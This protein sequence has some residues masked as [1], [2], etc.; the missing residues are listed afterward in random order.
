MGIDEDGWA[1]GT[2]LIDI[3][4]LSAHDL[5]C[6]PDFAVNLRRQWDDLL[7]A[8]DYSSCHWPIRD[9]SQ[10]LTD[11]RATRTS[12]D[13]DPTYL[14]SPNPYTDC[15]LW[16]GMDGPVER[17]SRRERDYSRALVE[18]PFT[19][20]LTSVLD[21]INQLQEIVQRFH[22]EQDEEWVE[23][24]AECT[25]LKVLLENINNT[26][27]RRPPVESVHCESRTLYIG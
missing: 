2:L 7:P 3:P 9:L 25:R 10:L 23:L 27:G 16:Q 15:P 18:F 21:I 11:P 8:H 24:V 1:P 17:K 13:L 5:L 20:V 22:R 4:R 19:V 12:L 26:R 14:R 6:R